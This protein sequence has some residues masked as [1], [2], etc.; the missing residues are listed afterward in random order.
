VL[1]DEFEGTIVSIVNVSGPDSGQDTL[2]NTLP[3]GVFW[4][5]EVHCIPPAYNNNHQK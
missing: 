1:K 3:V 4:L 5:I 2:N